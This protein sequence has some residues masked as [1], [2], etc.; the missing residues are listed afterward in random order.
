MIIDINNLYNDKVSALFGKL[1]DQLSHEIRNNLNIIL[2]F[3]E[4]M[5][6]TIP[7]DKINPETEEM[8]NKI[9]SAGK[10]IEKIFKDIDF[11]YDEY[12]PITSKVKNVSLVE[13]FNTYIKNGR[14]ILNKYK[15]K[16]KLVQKADFSIKINPYYLDRIFYNI[17]IIL[18]K[19]CKQN[20]DRTIIVNTDPIEPFFRFTL[21]TNEQDINDTENFV[22]S[23]LKNNINLIFLSKISE[24]LNFKL[25]FSIDKESINISL[26]CQ[27]NET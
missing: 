7:S 5:I 9:L 17:L 26:S 27:N 22:Y 4:L 23:I 11:L 24:K 1:Y 16:I 10:N 6:Y 20:F 21:Y 25:V 13:N 2:G 19:L 15:L 12:T 14:N 3:S 8:A 18:G